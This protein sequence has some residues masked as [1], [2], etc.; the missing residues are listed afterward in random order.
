MFLRF[1][2]FVQFQKRIQ[3]VLLGVVQNKSTDCVNN[4]CFLQSQDTNLIPLLK[5]VNRI[6][7]PLAVVAPTTVYLRSNVSHSSLFFYSLGAET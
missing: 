1:A 3:I 2:F 7:L 6:E 4:C 5:I